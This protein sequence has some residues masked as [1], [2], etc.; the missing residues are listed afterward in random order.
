MKYSQKHLIFL[1]LSYIH[2][3]LPYTLI[4]YKLNNLDNVVDSLRENSDSKL[5]DI[6]IFKLV[7]ELVIIACSILLI[8]IIDLEVE[9]K[10]LPMCIHFFHISME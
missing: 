3:K 9:L 7:I 6:L 5:F 4:Q 2:S 10:I 1:R 8:T